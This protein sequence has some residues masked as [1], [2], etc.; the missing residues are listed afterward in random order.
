M[1][2]SNS[3]MRFTLLFFSIIALVFSTP[4][5]GSSNKAIAAGTFTI[6]SKINLQNLNDV[7]KL[8][9]VTSANGDT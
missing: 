8:K 6:E 3:G 7:G 1:Q 5:L 9:V 2:K 4:F